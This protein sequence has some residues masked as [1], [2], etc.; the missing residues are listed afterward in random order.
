MPLKDNKLREINTQIIHPIVDESIKA[1]SDSGQLGSCAEDVHRGIKLGA[2]KEQFNYSA[3][4]RNPSSKELEKLLNDINEFVSKKTNAPLNLVREMTAHWNQV[5]FLGFWQQLFFKQ[6]P[7][8]ARLLQL[9]YVAENPNALMGDFF[10]PHQNCFFAYDPNNKELVTT[11]DTTIKIGDQEIKMQHC[12]AFSLPYK[13][14][15]VSASIGSEALIK[16]FEKE[17]KYDDANFFK[18]QDAILKDVQFPS[19]NDRDALK[20]KIK[21]ALNDIKEMTAENY[22]N[23]CKKIKESFGYEGRYFI[24][25]LLKEQADT[26]AEKIMGDNCSDADAVKKYN[27]LSKGPDTEIFADAFLVRLVKQNRSLENI[28]L[29]HLVYDKEEFSLEK[30]IESFNIAL[31]KGTNKE[32]AT[33]FLAA[34]ATVLVG[35]MDIDNTKSIIGNYKAIVSY[36]VP[37]EWLEAFAKEIS[38][39][40]TNDDIKKEIRFALLQNNAPIMLLERVKKTGNQ[41]RSDYFESG[42]NGDLKSNFPNNPAVTKAMDIMASDNVSSVVSTSYL[43]NFTKLFLAE[44][45]AIDAGER[46]EGLQRKSQHNK[47]NANEKEAALARLAYITA[48]LD[49]KIAAYKIRKDAP[50]ENANKD[51]LTA[52]K[53]I[54]AEDTKKIV[55]A[56]QEHIGALNKISFMALKNQRLPAI[57]VSGGYASDMRNIQQQLKAVIDSVQAA[58]IETTEIKRIIA[59]PAAEKSDALKARNGFYA[60]DDIQSKLKYIHAELKHREAVYQSRVLKG[61]EHEGLGALLGKKGDEKSATAKLA[62][63]QA[64]LGAIIVKNDAYSVDFSKFRALNQERLGYQFSS[65][66]NVAL[67]AAKQGTLGEVYH[68]L[69][70]VALPWQQSA[71]VQRHIESQRNT[72][73]VSPVTTIRVDSKTQEQISLDTPSDGGVA[74][75]AYI[76]SSMET[77]NN[78]ETAKT[79]VADFFRS[80]KIYFCGEKNFESYL[81]ENNTQPVSAA[82]GDGGADAS[83]QQKPSDEKQKKTWI[84]FFKKQNPEFSND[85]ILTEFTNQWNQFYL[86]ASTAFQIRLPFI[87]SMIGNGSKFFR[88]SFPYTINVTPSQ[89]VTALEITVSAPIGYKSEETFR[90]LCMVTQK[91]I[92]KN[93]AQVGEAPRYEV[94]YD[95]TEFSDPKVSALVFDNQHANR[96]YDAQRALLEELKNKP[97]RFEEHGDKPENWVG[98]FDHAALMQG[99]EQSVIES[100]KNETNCAHMNLTGVD[101]SDLDLN[102]KDFNNVVV[103]NETQ[104]PAGNCDFKKAFT[105]QY[106]FGKDVLVLLTT[107]A[108]FKAMDGFGFVKSHLD[109]RYGERNIFAVLRV[110]QEHPD[111][112]ISKAVNEVL[113]NSLKTHLIKK[114]KEKRRNINP[115][116][117]NMFSDTAV[118]YGVTRENLFKALGEMKG[119]AGVKSLQ[120]CSTTEEKIDYYKNIINCLKQ[121]YES[122]V[123]QGEAQKFHHEFFSSFGYSA[124]DKLK[125]LEDLKLDDLSATEL[126]GALNQGDLG[127]A[128]REL[129][130]LQK[131]QQSQPHPN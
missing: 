77:A 102:G 112:A 19:E 57:P 80:P 115:V 86:Y 127:K 87:C 81:S 98:D 12:I 76:K 131:E 109:D 63:T 14:R 110:A 10:E 25:P 128:L 6:L 78:P 52:K 42:A 2:D 108:F 59:K 32:S 91:L 16:L 28:N 56:M 79:F 116:E 41:N 20:E 40:I 48:Q 46:Y 39:K 121:E 103:N 95:S 55:Q 21:N 31:N 117:L 36:G 8:L 33:A 85:K 1:I 113:L 94:Q 124:Q 61:E 34:V 105:V 68:S 69:A 66:K 9:H 62:A 35:T 93:A 17:G 49:A 96:D 74:A 89:D 73:T 83:Q 51:S 100:V 130:K 30:A 84:D 99:F 45:T 64:M 15:F 125:A 23:K 53:I 5:D 97:N 82:G 22:N 47:S 50:T 75:L 107:D 58:T 37:Q 13:A 90:E 72:P 67:E 129:Q 114:A 92:F 18:E 29:G 70:Q 106:N 43:K 26:V 4:K 11:V 122:R 24:P 27:K 104:F 71:V 88:Y 3:S 111:Y 120:E 54:E 123:K 65:V 101:L 7:Y 119:G 38:N 126:K 60:S 44:Q 118:R